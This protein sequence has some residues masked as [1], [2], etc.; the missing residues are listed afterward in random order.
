MGR[1]VVLQTPVFAGPRRAKRAVRVPRKHVFV[2]DFN[3]NGRVTMRDAIFR[4]VPA[5]GECTTTWRR[6]YSS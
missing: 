5:H 6:L 3:A 2:R 1:K 4:V